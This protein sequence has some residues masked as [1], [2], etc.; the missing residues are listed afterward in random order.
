MGEGVK[1]RH[2]YYGLVKGEKG[3]KIVLKIKAFLTN[4][5]EL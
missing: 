4:K 1:S 5:L 2:P 3:T